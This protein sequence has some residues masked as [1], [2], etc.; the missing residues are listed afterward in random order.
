MRVE[1]I[2]GMK[3]DLPIEENLGVLLFTN[4]S[5]EIYQG[6]GK[7]K[8]LTQYSSV[9][10]GYKSLLDLE[11]KNPQV[12]GKIFITLDGDMYIYDGRSYVLVNG[13]RGKE[14]TELYQAN[15]NNETNS[16]LTK[17]IDVKDIFLEKNM[18]SIDRSE[19]LI[20]NN[21]NPSQ[22]Q[23]NNLN[24]VVYDKEI[25]IMD[26]LIEPKDAQKY[27]L[28][29]SPNIKVFIK[30]NFSATL[31]MNYFKLT[32]NEIGGSYYENIR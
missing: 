7:G 32:E 31:Y 8:P 22:T 24:L 15:W 14:S 25:K 28:G 17:V 26:T 9:I 6:N 3:T 20:Q 21:S 16:V 10:Y 29:I 12:K 5:G 19:L 4:D 30:G 23:D 11:T 1:F 13:L 2:Q 18:K 27:L